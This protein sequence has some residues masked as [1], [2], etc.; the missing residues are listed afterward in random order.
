[1]AQG[2]AVEARTLRFPT[3]GKL[4]VDQIETK[5]LTKVM[6]L[7]WSIKTRTADEVRGQVEQIWMPPEPEAS[8]PE[9]IR[10]AGAA[11]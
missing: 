10:H 7:L 3:I 6:Q 11:I 4:S 1:M 5:H 9:R 8:G 2:L